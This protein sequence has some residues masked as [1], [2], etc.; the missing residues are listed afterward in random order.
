MKLPAHPVKTG[1]AGRG[2]PGTPVA[3]RECEQRKYSIHIV[4]LDPPTWR[5]LRGTFRSEIWNR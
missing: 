5:G 4:P 1:Q 3:N 2:F